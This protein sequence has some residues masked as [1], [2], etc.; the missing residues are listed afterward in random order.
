MVSYTFKDLF[1]E[2]KVFYLGRS[3][4]KDLMAQVHL[5]VRVGE[6]FYAQAVL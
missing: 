6:N 5:L 2:T 4:S 1:N 3:C